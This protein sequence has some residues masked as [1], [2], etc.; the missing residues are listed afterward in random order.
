MAM[1]R[2]GQQRRQQ[3]KFWIAQT[4][5]PRTA[6]HPFYE[7]LNQVLAERGF[8]EFVE[9]QCERFYA[10][11]M[12]RPSLT[13]GRY[14]RLL[15]VGYFEGL[16]GERGI[17][18]RAADSLALRRFLELELSEQPPDHSTISRTRR[19]IDVETHQAVFRW[20]LELLA[21]KGLLKGNTVGID[22]TTL[23]ANAAMRSIVRRETG[24]SYEEFLRQLAQASG[25]ATPT[26]EQLAKLDRKRTKTTSND[27]WV[28]PHD[29]EAGI[30]KMKDGRTHLA[31][32]AEHAVD[33]ET[34]AVVAVTVATGDAG[35]TE[36]ML[37]T[38]PQAGEN[39]AEVA[40]A[41]NHEEVG[42]R[43]HPE[44]PAETV[45][46]K[47]YHSNDTL[48]ALKEAEVRAYISEP[49]RGPRQWKGKPQAQ[50]AVYSNRRR[51][52]GE[53]GQALLRRRGELLE[54]SF[55]HA[56]ETGRMR[57]VYLRGRDNVLKRV[58]IHVGALNLSLVMRKLWGKGT[59]RGFQGYS[60]DAVLAFLRLWMA[61]LAQ[62][63]ETFALP[64]EKTPKFR[65]TSQFCCCLLRH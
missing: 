10:E 20:V 39:I 4:E 53:H 38:L 49:D 44:G 21:E 19:L 62:A 17:A 15:L 51:I 11:T 47:G 41:T 54:R 25:I 5:L 58:L 64:S 24:E 18:W 56:Y 23:E 52:Q 28:N 63:E 6:G 46:D 40:C 13:P 37:E 35:D 26:R 30:T 33:L 2:R 34:G 50:A 29:P 16:D 8:D 12:G 7:R 14:F 48:V 59:P 57:R 31:Y 3:A 61:L 9:E 65:H 36:T 45:A 32:K 27:D 1:G 43:V 60:A 42:E 55:A 22:A